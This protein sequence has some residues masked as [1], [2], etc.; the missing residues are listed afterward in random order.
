MK[1][2]IKISLLIGILLYSAYSVYAQVPKIIGMLVEQPILT[3]ICGGFGFTQATALNL[4][5]NEIGASSLDLTDSGLGWYATLGFDDGGA[6]D[7]WLAYGITGDTLSKTASRL[8]FSGAVSEPSVRAILLVQPGGTNITVA[9]RFNST[10]CTTG[11]T[12]QRYFRYTSTLA[13][14]S[15]NTFADF[16]SQTDVGHATKSTD[17]VYYH[18]Y[19]TS[20]GGVGQIFRA[21]NFTSG[22]DVIS[23]QKNTTLTAVPN[24]ITVG[25]TNKLYADVGADQRIYEVNQSNLLINRSLFIGQTPGYVA[26]NDTITYIDQTTGGARLCRLV[27]SSFASCSHAY[28]WTGSDSSATS[29]IFVDSLNNK[30]YVLRNNGTTVDIIIRLRASDLVFEA[31]AAITGGVN[32]LIISAESAK[33]HTVTQRI[34]WIGSGGAGIPAQVNSIRTCTNIIG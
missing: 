14:I 9:Y 3:G 34:T 24:N 13:D 27:I 5:A 8:I 19:S 1:V 2:Q 31:R 6:E 33:F 4:A 28:T 17:G 30:V 26:A 21:I 11:G 12:C 23:V 20:T 7:R 29:T 22:L 25:G 10:G 16:N 32:N 18:V 15:N